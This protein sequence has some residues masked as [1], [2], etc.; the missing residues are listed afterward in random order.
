MLTLLLKIHQIGGLYLMQTTSLSNRMREGEKILVGMVHLL[1]LPGTLGYGGDIEAIYARALADA[2]ALQRAGVDA[3]IVENT[4][5]KPDAEML[6]PE[7]LA[8]LAAATRLVVEKVSVPVGVDAAFTDA[9]AG[10]AIANAANAAF[11]RCPVFVDHMQ[12]TGLGRVYPRSKELVRYRRLIG[13]EHIGIWADVQ[14]K[15]SHQMLDSVS[16]AESAEV[17]QAHGAEV[18]IVTGAST[19]LETP[20]DTVARVKSAVSCPVIVG[21]GFNAQNAAQQ[22]SVAD[23]AIVGTAMKQGRDTANPIDPQLAEGLMSVVRALK[24]QAA[25]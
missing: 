24:E 10:I 18:I 4:N 7:Q 25:Q 6:E 11:I 8:V 5:D 17:A 23:G 9:V 22:F 16:L 13:A 14:V 12:V 2:E 21:S 15:H 20:L 3:M 19:G 1:P